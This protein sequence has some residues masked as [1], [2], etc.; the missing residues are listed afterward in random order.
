M[1]IDAY[2]NRGAYVV[3]RP[4][5]LPITITS[6]AVKVD[7]KDGALIVTN[8]PDV[9]FAL[10]PGQWLTVNVDP[11]AAADFNKKINYPPASQ[12]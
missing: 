3:H 9:L 1:E 6:G 10:A 7:V 5:G 4:A 12:A 11:V 2:K 8:G